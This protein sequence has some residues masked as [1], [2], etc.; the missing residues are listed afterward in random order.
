MDDT[1]VQGGPEE[2]DTQSIGSLTLL[3]VLEGTAENEGIFFAPH[4]GNKTT[5]EGHVLYKFGKRS[6]YIHQDVIFVEELNKVNNDNEYIP[7]S[8]EELLEKVL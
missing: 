2:D 5:R 7:C 8:I 6:I 1:F 4:K 3:D